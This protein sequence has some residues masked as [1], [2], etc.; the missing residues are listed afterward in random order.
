MV[1][2]VWLVAHIFPV[3]EIFVIIK[4]KGSW[5]LGVFGV[6]FWPLY[7]IVCIWETGSKHSKAERMY[8]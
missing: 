8:Q 3:L 7:F 6:E 2:R 4:A 1:R 5:W